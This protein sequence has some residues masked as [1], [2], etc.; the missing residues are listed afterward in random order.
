[1]P[2]VEPSEMSKQAFSVS[3][4]GSE[5]PDHHSIDVEALAPALLA[6]GRLIREANTEFNGKKSTAK[7]VVVSDFEHKCFNI[8]FEA[9]V[10][11]YEQ[12]KSLLGSDAAKTAKEILEWIGLL[13]PAGLAGVGGL[14]YL[15]YLKWKNGRRVEGVT[16]ADQTGEG[17]VVV[18]VEGDN[19][20]VTVHNHVYKLS[21]NSKALRATRDAFSPI[22]TDGFDKIQ[23]RDSAGIFEEITSDETK[24]IIASCNN[25][26]SETGEESNETEET[27]AWLSVY[28]PVY[29]LKAESWRFRLGT[30]TANV[31][32]SETDIARDAIAR[33]GAL[34]NDSYQV[35]LE[36]TTPTSS[37]G[38]KGK[39]SYRVLKVITFIPG[40]THTQG[41]LFPDQKDDKK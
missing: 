12:I 19:S 28:S 21:E 10:G 5:R 23:L 13:N 35:R 15:G 4:A 26:L 30:E 25:E 34:T 6:F 8:N 22:G 39:P 32:I 33:G 41:S 7:V 2:Q 3:Y 17:N 18:K 24:A 9:I 38:K 16:I 36:I 31:D 27:T 11:V 1:M 37:S 29:D 40:V 14:T 20:P